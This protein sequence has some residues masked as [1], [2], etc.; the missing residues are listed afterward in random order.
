MLGVGPPL[1]ELAERLEVVEVVG[2]GW[3]AAAAAAAP[4]WAAVV[5][6]EH[7]AGPPPRPAGRE[8]VPPPGLGRNHHWPAGAAGAGAAGRECRV[9]PEWS[10]SKPAGAG[11]AVLLLAD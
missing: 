5:G 6:R 7:W 10:G 2:R 8:L 1:S 11:P 3:A 4:R 9:A